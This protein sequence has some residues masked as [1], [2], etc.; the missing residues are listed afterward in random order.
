L[1]FSNIH[2]IDKNFFQT[3]Q[4]LLDALESEIQ[5]FLQDRELA[6]GTLIS[7]N[8]TEFCVN[9]PSLAEEIKI[10]DY[11]LRLL[12]AEDQVK[13]I[14]SSKKHENFKTLKF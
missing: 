5:A 13:Q 10:G 1:C 7:W 14:C 3:R 6:G 12:L 8:Y 9:Y 4:E 2:C 11:F